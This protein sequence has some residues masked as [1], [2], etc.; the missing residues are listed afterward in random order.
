MGEEKMR[1][2]KDYLKQSNIQRME[3]LEIEHREKEGCI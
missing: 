1:K 2:F 3:V